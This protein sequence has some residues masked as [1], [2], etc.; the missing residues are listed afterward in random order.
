MGQSHFLKLKTEIENSEEQRIAFYDSVYNLILNRE[1]FSPIKWVKLGTIFENECERLNLRDEFKEADSDIKLLRA[2]HKL[3]YARKDRHLRLDATKNFMRADEMFRVPL[4]FYPDMSNE[5]EVF[6]FVANMSERAIREGVSRGDYLVSIDGIPIDE[7]IDLLSP[8][9]RYS[10]R[11][12]ML[13]KEIPAYLGSKSYVFGPELLQSDQMK[14]QLYQPDD[15]EIYEVYLNYEYGENIDWVYPSVLERDREGNQADKDYYKDLYLSFGFEKVYDDDLNCALYVNHTNKLALIEWYHFEETREGAQ[16]L[17]LEA[18]NQD[19]LD[20][21]VIVDATHSGGGSESALLLQVLAESSFKTTFG[22]VRVSDKEFATKHISSYSS[23]IRN[24]VLD[25][26]NADQEYTTNEPFKLQLF[27][28]GSDGIM[29]PASISFKG[30]KVALFFTLG[31]SN[32]DQFAAMIA[33]NSQLNIH[34]IGMPTGGYS[35]TWE[36]GESLTLLNRTD[37]YFEWDVG[38]TIRPNGEILEGNPAIPNE[39]FPFTS[40][41]YKHYFEDLLQKGINYLTLT[42]INQYEKSPMNFNLKVSNPVRNVADIRFELD[43]YSAVEISILD[44]SGRPVQQIKEKNYEAGMN[45]IV[46]DTKNL[47]KGAYL[48]ILKTRDGMNS[49]KIIKV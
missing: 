2:L 35:N 21:D 25:A 6:F 16:N 26:I 7:Y 44:M 27:P 13:I 43:S 14:L 48:L 47:R 4:R 32:L 30:K 37:T 49:V 34:T 22:N 23:S 3:N 29:Y 40:D 46:C 24:W 28:R 36:W 17:M 45:Q 12:H 1:A 10:T 19:I 39:L 9:L 31:G 38:H 41:N 15:E 11:P 5:A 33:D 42:A 18:Q 8:Y 20:Y